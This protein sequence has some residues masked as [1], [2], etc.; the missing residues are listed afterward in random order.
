MEKFQKVFDQLKNLWSIKIIS[1]VIALFSAESFG[2]SEQKIIASF[3]FLFFFGFSTWG[4]FC[5]EDEKI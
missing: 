1:G 5:S 3:L 4:F 2:I